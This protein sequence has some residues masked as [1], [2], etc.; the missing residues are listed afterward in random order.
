MAGIVEYVLIFLLLHLK[1]SASEANNVSEAFH[2][3]N[4]VPDMIPVAP[5]ALVKVNIL[6]LWSD[7]YF[8]TRATLFHLKITEWRGSKYDRFFDFALHLL[9]GFYHNK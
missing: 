7:F 4:V 6:N 1:I 3:F 5:S 8:Y 2:K 9:Q